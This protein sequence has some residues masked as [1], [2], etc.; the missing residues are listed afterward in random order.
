MENMP[1][2]IDTEKDVFI[3][4]YSYYGQPE[5]F[6]ISTATFCIIASAAF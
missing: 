2:L 4:Q 1:M 3:F 6:C 5:L